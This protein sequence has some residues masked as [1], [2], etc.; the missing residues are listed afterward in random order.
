[1]CKLRG[2]VLVVA[3][4]VMLGAEPSRGSGLILYELG[5]PDVGLASAGYAA[6][7]QDAATAVTNPAG[8]ARLERSEFVLGAQMLYGDVRFTP[9]PDTTH[10]GSD[11]G[12]II[13]WLPG[14]AAFYVHNASP[15]VKIGFSTYANFGLSY[16]YD[17]DWVGRYHT[18]EGTLLGLT[19]A[20][21][22]S[23]RIN[24]RF[25]VGAA[26][27]AMYGIFSTKTAVNNISPRQGDGEISMESEEWGF[28]TTL[29]LLYEITDA[30]R[31]GLTYTS[32]LSLDF[33]DKPDFD[34][35]G[36]GL[37][38]IL[39][40]TGLADARLGLEVTVPQRLMFSA[41]H[42]LNDRWAILGNLGWEDWSRFGK[43]GVRIDSESSR[44][45]TVEA[46]FKD[47][48]HAA[49]GAQY[50]ASDD[51]LFSFGV[52]YDSPMMDDDDRPPE[53]AAGEA[54]RFGAGAVHAWSDTLEVGFGYTLAW[55]GDL[56]MDQEGGRLSGRLQGE[57]EDVALH[58]FAVNFRWKF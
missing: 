28:G 49:I 46:E 51:W 19:L 20:P 5:A 17:D 35:L 4:L 31:M 6:R 22:V 44:S 30:T 23:Y 33:D 47:T 54:W 1:M 40:R 27:N 57:Y 16:D 52:A 34:D 24:P 2:W 41:F 7:A 43:V 36:P 15:D 53:L 12:N 26:L 25:S 21:S 32:Q 13:G 50:R 8:M 14:G 9:G 58:F 3:I 10:S 45:L 48:W 18:R 38:A 56:P 55:S 29:G 37:S 42:D 39:E 11:G